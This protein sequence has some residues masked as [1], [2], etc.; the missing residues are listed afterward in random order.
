MKTETIDKLCASYME[1]VRGVKRNMPKL[2]WKRIGKDGLYIAIT[3]FN[4]FYRIE[5]VYNEFHLFCNS[6]F[7]SCYIS[8]SDAKQAANEHYKKQIKKALGV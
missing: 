4:W 2:K 8:L 5:F 7:I 1:D 3:V 6:Y